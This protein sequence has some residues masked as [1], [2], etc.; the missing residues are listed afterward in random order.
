MDMDKPN[1]RFYQNFMVTEPEP[2]P[3]QCDIAR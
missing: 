3:K 1:A 2:K